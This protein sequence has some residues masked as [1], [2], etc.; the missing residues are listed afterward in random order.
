MLRLG[1]GEFGASS[2]QLSSRKASTRILCSGSHELLQKPLSV[3][4]VRVAIW[5]DPAEVLFPVLCQDL[6]GSCRAEP[7]AAVLCQLCCRTEVAVVAVV[8]LAVAAGV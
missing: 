3:L 4:P 8:A 2:L 1:P 6:A 7:M 5:E